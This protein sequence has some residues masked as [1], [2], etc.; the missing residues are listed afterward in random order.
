MMYLV[1]YNECS[2]R[3]LLNQHERME[4][5][6]SKKETGIMDKLST[7]NSTHPSDTDDDPALW[8]TTLLI[9]GMTCA[10]CSSR[11]EKGLSRMEGV[12]QANVNLAMEKATISY[13]PANIGIHDF[14][15]KV[16][17]LGFQTVTE[18]VDLNITGM[19]CAACSARI[20]KGLTKLPGGA[21]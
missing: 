16:E 8:Q 6:C 13:D 2:T 20:E 4:Q 14:R 19:T 5:T 9:K 12:Q 17:A 18:S 1:G 21:I 7:S 11:I 15:N 10:A 3:L